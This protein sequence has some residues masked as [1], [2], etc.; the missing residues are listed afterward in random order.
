MSYS[1]ESCA[2]DYPYDDTRSEESLGRKSTSPFTLLWAFGL[3]STVPIVNLGSKSQT[4]IAY[5][6]AHIAVIYDYSARELFPLQGHKH[7]VESLSVDQSGRWLFSADFGKDSTLVIWDIDTKI[8][9][10]TIFNPHGKHGL[11][12]ASLSP[13]AKY[14]VTIGNEKVQSVKIWMWTLGKKSPDAENTIDDIGD[15]RVKQ[16]SFNNENVTIFA[17][18]TDQRVLFAIWDRNEQKCNV[19]HPAIMKKPSNYGVLNNTTFLSKST[20]AF[21]GTVN[22]FILVWKVEME[23]GLEGQIR[24][25]HIKTVSLQ[26]ANITRIVDHDGMI[27]TGNSD[28]E[29][30]FYDCDLKIL[31][32]CRDC[33]L[34][35]IVSISF[36]LPR[37]ASRTTDS[38]SA[39]DLENALV[40]NQKNA[41][42]CSMKS[43]DFE[44]MRVPC[45]IPS[46]TAIN[47]GYLPKSRSRKN[48]SERYLRFQEKF[49]KFQVPRDATLA[50]QEFRVAKLIVA[51]K[52]G[53]LAWIDISR[54]KCRLISNYFE[55]T[56]TAMDT[57]PLSEYFVTSDANGTIFLFNYANRQ[58]MLKKSIPPAPDLLQ[59]LREEFSEG[60][61]NHV[62]NLHNYKHQNASYCTVLK[63]SPS[64]KVL[65]C[66]TDNGLMWVLHPDTL[67]PVDP[68]PY[69]HS[70]TVI[71]G[72][73][74]SECSSYVACYDAA[75][76]VIVLK[77]ISHDQKENPT[78][79]EFI[80]KFRSHKAPIKQLLFGK[81]LEE[82]NTTPR[83]LSLSEDYDLIEYD[84]NKSG[85][86]PKPGLVIL[87]VDQ[88]RLNEI[89]L[90][91]NW[92]P[93]F[94]NTDESII[95]SNSD[96]KFNLIDSLRKGVEAV[97]LGPTFTSPVK[98][99]IICR[100][101]STDVT[102]YMVFAS[103]KEIGLQLL[104]FDGNP[105]KIIGLI[106]HPQEISWMR[107]SSCGKILFTLG[108]DDQSVL[109]WKIN[110]RAVDVMHRLGG[111]G[112]SPFY[113]LINAGKDGWLFN[114]MQDLFV[115]SQILQQGV[116]TMKTREIS[117]E[118]SIKQLPNLLRAIGF[119]PSKYELKVLMDQISKEVNSVG[120]HSDK[121]NFE[122]FVK[123]YINYRPTFGISTQ[124]IANAFRIL[125]Q[126]DDLGEDFLTKY[127][128]LDILSG[129]TNVTRQKSGQTSGEILDPHELQHHLSELMLRVADGTV[130]KQKKSSHAM[131]QIIDLLSDRISYKDF[132]DKIM[133]IKILHETEVDI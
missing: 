16:I 65:T 91:M 59:I 90:S 116:N 74:F 47:I 48:P 1:F 23:S 73:E 124:Q 64:G 70:S 33:G 120:K 89:P 128:F 79:Y 119:Y 55:S 62:S 81:P 97:I 80:G 58:L 94:H 54:L 24:A 69:R 63:Y 50:D 83:L 28:G 133:G 19:F 20:K 82:Q 21:T 103:T 4:L 86:Y 37:R 2:E 61:I 36:D 84:L 34:D 26:K 38:E 87:R 117:D 95:I 101:G 77:A 96:Y 121:I 104:P 17:L 45:E 132:M 32:W 15:E 3:N 71:L 126:K 5:A 6:C 102:A 92:Y 30:N 27:I 51:T 25:Q 125:G 12:A 75:M 18:T 127:E 9:I 114:E 131:D 111:T 109:M 7:Y 130:T 44:D 122:E 14:V 11:T 40:K 106:G 113:C 13:D 72:T 22:G 42:E 105:Y 43:E 52:G 46:N 57:H 112:L 41:N 60:R 99:T 29:I 98:K 129:R 93:Q 35:S 107:I 118:V 123:L 76:T 108:R 100:H 85:P 31:Y 67:D 53:K 8:P 110:F 39:V 88:I 66:A 115:F 68:V 49:E 56:L 10:C 78:H